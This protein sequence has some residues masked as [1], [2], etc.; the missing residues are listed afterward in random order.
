MAAHACADGGTIV[1]LAECADGLGRSDFL[2]WFE[3]ANSAALELRLRKNY[4]V[5]GQTA[6]ALM[7][8]AEN[9]RVHILTGLDEDRVRG[10][11]MTPAISIESILAQLSLNATGY[12]M[13][14]GAALL[15]RTET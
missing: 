4:E 2:K 6:W 7:T 9:F 11:R 13:P 3:S 8:K 1:L 10:M 12:I 15:P 14:R 5:N